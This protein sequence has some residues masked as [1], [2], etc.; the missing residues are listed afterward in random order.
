MSK[1]AKKLIDKK[2]LTDVLN[3][4]RKRDFYQKGNRP[5]F[6]RA[7]EHDMEVSRLLDLET[8]E[9]LVKS[10]RVSS[11][12]KNPTLIEQAKVVNSD[13]FFHMYM[14]ICQVQ[15]IQDL[16]I[17]EPDDFSEMALALKDIQK[18]IK[19]EV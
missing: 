5:D 11:A 1:K 14:A 10:Y 18:A 2:K 9:E 19:E 6:K 15:A 4:A 13:K 8:L 3:A 7:C 17:I 16:D 12:L